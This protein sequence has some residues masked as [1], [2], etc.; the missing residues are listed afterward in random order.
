M[1]SSFRLIRLFTRHKVAANLLMALMILSGVWGLSKLNVQFLPTYNVDVVSVVIVWNGASAEDVENSIINPLEQDLRTIDH[2]KKMTSTS[3][4]G[5]GTIFIEFEEGSDMGKALEDVREKVSQVRNLPQDSEKPVITRVEPYERV[6]RLVFTGPKNLEEL[7][8]L[9]HQFERELLDAGIGKISILGLPEQEIAI[10]IAIAK[11]VEMKL[12]LSQIAERIAARSVDLPAGAIGKSE[13]SR[14][15]RSLDQR[16]D[17]RGFENLPIVTDDSGQLIRLGDI[18][19]IEKQA[20]D[21]ETTV[22]YQGQPAV[23][24]RLLRTESANALQSA[25]IIHQWLEEVR[26]TLGESLKVRLYDERWQYIQER[27]NLLLKNGIGGLILIIAILFLFLNRRVALWVV[28]GIPTSFMAAIAV[29]YI[30]GGSINMVSLFAFIMAL[31]IIVD[32]TIVIGEQTLTNIQ[33]GQR[34]LEAI[35]NA[36]HKM[37]APIMSSSLTTICAFLPLFL[38]S[39]IIGTILFTIPLVV[40]CVILASLLECFFVLPGHLHHSFKH[41]RNEDEPAIRRKINTRFNQFKEGRFRQMIQWSLRNRAITIV[42]SVGL[43]VLSIGLVISGFVNFTFF[44]SPEG[45]LIQSSTQFT[46]GTP[47][48]KVREFMTSI[49]NALYLTNKQLSPSGKSLLQTG[50]SYQNYSSINNYDSNRGEQYASMSVELISPEERDITNTEFIKAWRNNIKLPPGVEN[51]TIFAPRGGPPGE[52]ID[53]EFSGADAKTLKKAAV[54]LKNTLQSIRGVSDIKDDLPFGQEQLIYQ[55]NNTGR[56]IGLTINDV[57]QQLR[58]AFNGQLAEI[59]HETNDEIEVRVMLPD[60]QRFSLA[61]LEHYP[62]ITSGGEAVPLG[63]I[64]DL[65]YRS[66]PD[67]LLHTDTKLTVHITAKV[68]NTVNN[69]NKVLTNINQ[70]AIPNLVKKYNLKVDLKG[71]AEEQSE[72]FADMKYGLMLGFTLIYIIL[73]WVFSSYGWPLVVMAAIPLGLTGAI[74]GHLVMGIDLTILSLFG[75][76]GLSGIV[77]NDSIILLSEYKLLKHEGMPI[78]TAISEAC[79]RRLRA[80]I[81]TSLTTI[82]GLTPL[83]FEQS[84]Q[85]QFLIPMAVSISFGLAYATLLILIVVPTL[86]S[87]Y[88]DFHGRFFQ[89]PA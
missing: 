27:I 86:L 37:L 76:F 34:T 83:L 60:K 5:S 67:V 8:P 85:A 45:R 50:V 57:G 18:A 43:F 26:P 15:L 9:I 12:S 56:S 49:E 79:C 4:I 48:N 38:I 66:G 77:I 81:L 78:N 30:Y 61:T 31:G 58:A 3:K 52:D 21:R 72:T 54:E 47:P 80:V 40:I 14:Q 10:K 35:E 75:L 11:L 28:V 74:I 32:D 84:L 46:A 13:I 70:N 1:T 51:F 36:V 23:E 59:Y 39:G 42:S 16:R 68:D 17:L 29:L 25:K 6:S 89:E 7:R 65:S 62:I 87:L 22:F 71:K 53:V 33:N 2:I 69:A 41:H 82:A 44:P 63:S 73:A 55:L 88:E 20:Q 24:M 19:V 64:V